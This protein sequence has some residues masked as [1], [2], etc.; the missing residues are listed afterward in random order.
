MATV[1]P[2]P[3]L[4]LEITPFA[5]IGVAPETHLTEIYLQ[6]PKASTMSGLQLR[7]PR[8]AGTELHLKP[9]LSA[10]VQHI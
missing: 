9:G 4:G 6:W 3:F 2:I 7:G 8:G 1:G 5:V 10:Y